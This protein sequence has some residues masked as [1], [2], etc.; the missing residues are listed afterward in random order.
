VTRILVIRRGGLG[1]TLLTA[2]LL[3]ALRRQHAGASLHLAGNREFC[4]ILCG[5]GVVEVAHSAEDFWLWLPDRAREHLAGFALVIGDEPDLVHAALDLH[6]HVTGIPYALQLARQVGCEPRWPSDA[7]LL[8]PRHRESRHRESHRESD[9]RV[10]L[11]PGSGGAK[12]CWPQEHWL[13]LAT[14]LAAAGQ[15]L[16]VV[17]GPVEN[18]R[19][20]L[21][22][23]PWPSGTT[24]LAEPR[25]LQLAR[26]LESAACFVGNDSGPTHLA[27]MLGVP[28]V[29]V[30]VA[31]DASVWAPV[32]DHV[33][34][35]G[36]A[37]QLH[38]VAAVETAWQSLATPR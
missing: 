5:Y 38:S 13:A 29:A 26:Q 8:P 32:G 33:R 22:S 11:A 7:Q 6:S 23:W 36:D 16:Q 10:V 20:D 3:R 30:F 31:T 4:D 14:R 9:A 2:P 17:I 35:V 27:A 15:A 18:E 21:R 19:L 1:D 37:G 28:T 34:V 25:A 12:K 24:L